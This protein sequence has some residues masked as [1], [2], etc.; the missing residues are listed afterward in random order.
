MDLPGGN[1][2]Q[3]VASLRRLA[4]LQADYQVHPGPGGSTAL[5]AERRYNPYMR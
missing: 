5:S 3:M 2:H 4:A 1:G